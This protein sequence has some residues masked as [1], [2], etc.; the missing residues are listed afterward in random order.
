M[1]PRMTVGKAD[2]SE[3]PSVYGG[4]ASGSLPGRE[5]STTARIDGLI[6]S[7]VAAAH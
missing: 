4:A 5:G 6:T 7:E 3:R 1:P 2:G